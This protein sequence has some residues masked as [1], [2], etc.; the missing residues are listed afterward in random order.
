MSTSNSFLA[1]RRTEIGD[2]EAFIQRCL[3]G[4]YRGTVLDT[5]DDVIAREHSGV[6]DEPTAADIAAA[7]IAEF[8]EPEPDHP[9]YGVFHVVRTVRDG[10]PLH[11]HPAAA[12][13][14][15][16]LSDHDSALHLAT[17]LRL[18]R[19]RDDTTGQERILS[20]Q[21]V[22]GCAEDNRP[23]Y[24]WL[25]RATRLATVSDATVV[26]DADLHRVVPPA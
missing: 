23:L 17:A 4:T 6:P 7:I 20:T 13:I 18:T 15:A 16:T 19:Y 1:H 8:D 5:A 2:D 25:R 26:A 12:R 21:Q 22:Q 14:D 10:Q 9:T 24:L 11:H 3:D